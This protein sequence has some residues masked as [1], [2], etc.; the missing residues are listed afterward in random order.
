MPV[1][2]L[3]L[4]SCR[5]RDL[6]CVDPQKFGWHRLLASFP[7]SSLSY[8]VFWPITRYLA[9]YALLHILTFDQ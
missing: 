1:L 7:L 5:I 9:G 3:P 4:Y 8:W 6:I 2:S